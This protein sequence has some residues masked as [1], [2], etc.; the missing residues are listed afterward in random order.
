MSLFNQN[1]LT[2]SN[3]SINR[4]IWDVDIDFT[5]YA[6]QTDADNA[7]PSSDTSRFRVNITDD[8]LDFN[9]DNTTDNLKIVHDVIGGNLPT[10]FYSSWKMRFSSLTQRSN[11]TLYV[12]F[13]DGDETVARTTAQDGMYFCCIN[14]S[15]TTDFRATATDNAGIAQGGTIA[16]TVSWATATDYY[17]E[18]IRD[19]DQVTCTLYSDADFTTTIQTANESTAN[20]ALRYFMIRN[21]SS[22]GSGDWVGTLDNFQYKGNTTTRPS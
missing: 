12:G 2:W 6:N 15:G 14:A 21:V 3:P 16:G 1:F 9:E 8:D 19:G 5:E 4:G 10:Q 18:L 7:W 13:T 17:F 20:I 22:V 11:T